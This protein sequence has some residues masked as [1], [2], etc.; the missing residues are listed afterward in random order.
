MIKEDNIINDKDKVQ[1]LLNQ[2]GNNFNF[3]K[4]NTRDNRK[5]N[6]QGNYN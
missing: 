2:I 1:Q 6:I 4:N 5:S 3:G